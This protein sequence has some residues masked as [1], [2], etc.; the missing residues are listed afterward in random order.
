MVE[1][2]QT[3]AKKLCDIERLLTQIYS[4]SVKTVDAKTNIYADY[5]WNMRIT[6]FK[7][8]LGHLN[9]LLRLVPEVFETFK[10][11]FKSDKLKHLCSLKPILMETEGE[12]E[13]GAKH[14][15]EFSPIESDSGLLDNYLPLLEPFETS[16]VWCQSSHHYMLPRPA[17]GMD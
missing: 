7:K 14:P 5:S 12:G 3:R 1:V 11:C 6:L 16:I 8:V 10:P 2:F 15:N 4:Y 13:K 17:K 9:Q